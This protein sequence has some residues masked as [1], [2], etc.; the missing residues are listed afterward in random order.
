MYIHTY[1]YVL[2]SSR[3]GLHVAY[4]SAQCPQVRESARRP[5][6]GTRV[7][8]SRPDRVTNH[9]GVA[10]RPVPKFERVSRPR[11]LSAVCTAL[12]TSACPRLRACVQSA[13]APTLR[14]S[15]SIHR[16]LAQASPKPR[17]SGPKQPVAARRSPSQYH[18]RAP[19]PWALILATT[20]RSCLPL[21]HPPTYV[22]A[23][24]WH[25]G[26]I[27]AF[28]PIARSSSSE[29]ESESESVSAVVVR[30]AHCV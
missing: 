3:Y 12:P 21:H 25:R 13:Q 14:S 30:V 20:I 7:S 15:S 19:F 5:R 26:D 18:R 29:S 8:P 9:A 11:R 27:P 28:S 22:T 10:G 1:I 2:R 16:Q 6:L 4:A 24:C 17:P 23:R